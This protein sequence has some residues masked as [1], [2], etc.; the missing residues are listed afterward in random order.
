MNNIYISPTYYQ[1]LAHTFSPGI[2]NNLITIG[3]SRY[4]T[5]VLSTSGLLNNVDTQINMREFFEFLYHFISNTYRNE[6]VYKNVITNKVLLGRHSLNSSSM[7][8]EFRVGNCKADVVILNNTSTVYEIKSEYDSLDRLEEQVS[9]YMQMFDKINVISSSSQLDKLETILP[10][11]IGIPELTS[12]N[13]IHTVREPTSGKRSVDPSVIFNSLRKPEYI[14]IIKKRFRY[15][16]DV[17]NTRIYKECLELFTTLS[18]EI[19]HDDMVRTLHD[20]RNRKSLSDCIQDIPFS[21][22]A[23]RIGSRVSYDNITNLLTLLKA[24][25]ET[26]L[27]PIS[28]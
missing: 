1:S 4:L 25:L 27:V 26:V 8:T 6:Y 14:D 10:S 13:K 24:R 22:R 18:P 11:E 21:L 15:I 9:S 20:R 3:Q 5:E 17:P 2:M 16:P 12:N 19:A 7:L 28:S 23:Y